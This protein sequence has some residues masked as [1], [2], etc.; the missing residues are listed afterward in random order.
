MPSRSSPSAIVI[1]SGIVGAATAYFLAKKG[2][3]VTLIDS[4]A[5]AAEATGAADGAVSVASKHPGPM[6]NTAL[7]GIALYREL[8]EDGLLAGLFKQRSTFIVAT[9]AEECAVLE[10]HAAALSS[11]GVNVEHLN[12]CA[13][14]RRFPVLSDSASLA[15]EVHAEGHAIGYQIVHRLITAAGIAVHRNTRANRLRLAGN[16]ERF[17]GVETENGFLAADAVVISAGSGSEHLVNV[18]AGLIPR[19]GQLLVTERAVALNASMPGAIMSGRYL[20]SKRTGNGKTARPERGFGLVIDPLQTGQFLIGGT[21]EAF[22]DRK[23]N[24]LQAVSRILSDAVAL[25]PG[26]A[27]LR[28]LRAFAGARTAVSDG[29]PLIGR[30][31][32]IE[33]GFIATGFEGDGICLGPVTGKAI[34]ELVTGQLPSID[35]GPFDPARFGICEVAA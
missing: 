20:L 28:L 2:V 19:K 25:V 22:G 27:R 16:G 5:P 23:V 32:G 9:S 35:L 24:D 3:S 12:S 11:A 7:K 10:A 29:L 1:G 31:P 26:L 14:H 4:S 6:M 15:V 33:N 18:G 13:L 8:A 30:L 34:A 21:R 17:E